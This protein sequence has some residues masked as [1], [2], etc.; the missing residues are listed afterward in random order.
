MLLKEICSE[1][2]LIKILR[3]TTIV[4]V[5]FE[6]VDADENDENNSW[7]DAVISLACL[8]YL[9]KKYPG[10][11]EGVLTQMKST[12]VTGKQL[13]E[14]GEF[15]NVDKFIRVGSGESLS[16]KTIGRAVEAVIGAFFLEEG[17]NDTLDRLNV[18]FQQIE[19][20]EITQVVHN[21]KGD[22][23]KF[24]QTT[25]KTDP[26]YTV[27]W[28]DGEDHNKQFNVCVFL[29]KK[30]Y[31]CGNG[32]SIKNAEQEAAKSALFSIQAEQGH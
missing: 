28:T 25:F 31:A 16:K 20:G 7:S 17:Y 23:Q 2:K 13:A 26:K 6:D 9:Y 19:S 8:D 14:I 5:D 21:Y 22:L 4:F 30:P 3:T 1:E 15:Y 18:I 24:C 11:D 10:Y 29:N 32:T 12:L 27:L